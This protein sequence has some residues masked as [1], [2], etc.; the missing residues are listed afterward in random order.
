MSGR[1]ILHQSKV[2]NNQIDISHLALGTYILT[3][4]D[5]KENI[6]SFQILKR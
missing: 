2:I 6:G 5:E 4:E 3:L 1:V